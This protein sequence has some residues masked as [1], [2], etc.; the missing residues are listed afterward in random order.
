MAK[1]KATRAG[2]IGGNMMKIG[3]V[4]ECVESEFS[5]MWMELVDGESFEAKVV[6]KRR[7]KKQVEAE[8]VEV[9][10][11]TFSSDFS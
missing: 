6:R 3:S 5:D 1:V 7:T 4:F 10:P 11:N 8:T 9:N 2:F